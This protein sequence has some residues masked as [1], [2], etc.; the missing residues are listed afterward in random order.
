MKRK[1]G[2]FDEDFLETL[3]MFKQDHDL[4]INNKLDY[5]TYKEIISEV[6]ITYALDENADPQLNKA[7]E[8]LNY[9]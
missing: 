6:S 3:L 1:D 9:D 5:D 4:T 8:L 7:K 2:Y